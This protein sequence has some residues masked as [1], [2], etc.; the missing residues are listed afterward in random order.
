MCNKNLESQEIVS[1]N[2]YCSIKHCTGGSFR[3]SI[4]IALSGDQV[5][6]LTHHKPTGAVDCRNTVQP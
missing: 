2:A 6:R 5:Y 1:I 3:I 4:R